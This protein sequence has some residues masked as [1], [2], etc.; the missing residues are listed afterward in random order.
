[1]IAKK[2]LESIPQSIRI[3]RKLSTESVTES[4]TLSQLRVLFLIKEGQSQTQMSET[5]DVSLPAM[6]KMIN[7]LEKKGLMNRKVS[8]DRRANQLVLTAKG[9]KFLSRVS[10][11]VTSELDAGIQK[12]TKTQRE[13]LLTGILVLDELMKIVK[14]V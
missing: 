2:L 12:L 4:L 8:D 14:E 10:D 9:K 3:I 1:M 7:C 11:Y 13:Q 5:L 6:S